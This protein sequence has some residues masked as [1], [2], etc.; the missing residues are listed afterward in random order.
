MNYL[1]ALQAMTEYR[2]TNN[3]LFIKALLDGG[4]TTGGTYTSS[5]EQ[6]VDLVM[7]DIYF[8]LAGH[9]EMIEGRWKVKYPVDKLYSLRKKIYDKWGLD[10]PENSNL[11][12][13]PELT[14]KH[15]SNSN[16][17]W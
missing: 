5:D 8:S 16:Y 4:L 7:A 15:A 12:N 9:P 14:A 6:A 3:N 10:L 11:N 2:S 13:V 1:E 17:I